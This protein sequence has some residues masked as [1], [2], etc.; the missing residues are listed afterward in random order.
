MTNTAGTLTFDNLATGTPNT[1]PGPSYTGPTTITGGKVVLSEVN[2]SPSNPYS[3]ASPVS[4]GTSATF[5]MNAV[6]SSNMLPAASI[7]L[8]G[9]GS[10]LQFTNTA[11]AYIVMEGSITANASSTINI[12]AG[13]VNGGANINL[14]IDG[15]LKGSAPVN[16][17]FTGSDN[18][19]TGLDIRD[20]PS[21]YSGTLTV[22]GTASTTITTASGLAVGINYSPANMPDASIV[23]NGTMEMGGGNTNI[24]QGGMGISNGV[25]NGV[26]FQMNALSGSGIVLADF[27]N[28]ATSTRTLSVGNYNG[29]ATGA[30]SFT[31]LIANSTDNSTLDTL[32]LIKN[33]TGT[34]TLAPTATFG[35][36][37]FTGLTT[38]NGGT[39]QLNDTTALFALAATDPVTLAGGT[40]GVQ[41]TATGVAVTQTVGAF[42]LATGSSD[43]VVLTNAGTATATNL[44]TG[45]FTHN[46]D[47]TLFLN[48]TSA[49]TGALTTSNLTTVTPLLGWAVVN[50]GSTIGFGSVNGS[51]QIVLNTVTTSVLAASGNVGTTDYT[52]SAT[53]PGYTGGTP[54]HVERPSGHRFAG[55][56]HQQRRGRA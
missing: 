22:G 8:N 53:D 50:N 13:V 1:E 42:T 19:G 51:K 4:V 11:A 17:T 21:N 30:N 37:T 7:S 40:L 28:L 32:S 29:S 16:V 18:G 36:N 54:T 2:A 31:G 52:T 9:V 24:T 41:G 38:F 23:I 43:S 44:T 55:G 14:Y 47:S 20:A 45:T 39:L 34:Q 48:L 5:V 46:A 15:G 27:P 49:G 35:S 12:A 33:G 26:T 56:Q 25:A 10:T 6:A 3:F